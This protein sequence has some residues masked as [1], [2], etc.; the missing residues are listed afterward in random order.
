MSSR[1]RVLGRSRVPDLPASGPQSRTRHER[2]N[3]QVRAKPY[4]AGQARL[5]TRAESQ[6]DTHCRDGPTS[7]LV[8][9]WP[10]KPK[11]SGSEWVSER[12]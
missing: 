9:S 4:P 2:R 11:N 10:P 12:A 5:Q 3:H 7:A 8:S 6:H 1:S